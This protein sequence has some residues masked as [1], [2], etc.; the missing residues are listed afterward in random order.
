M[1][2]LSQNDISIIGGAGHIGLPLALAFAEKKFNVHLI[3]N[4]EKNLNLIKSN[5]MPFLEFGAEKYLK[6]ALNKNLLS[7]ET[8]LKNLNE[9]DNTYVE[10]KCFNKSNLN[11]SNTGGSIKCLI[12]GIIFNLLFFINL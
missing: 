6:K 8:D 11:L 4:N 1:K 10:C 2:N 3:D 5:K 7:F 9:L 12:L